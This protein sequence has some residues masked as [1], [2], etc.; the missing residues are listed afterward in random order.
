MKMTFALP[1]LTNLL[2]DYAIAVTAGVILLGLVNWFAF[3]RK[4]YT[5][6]SEVNFHY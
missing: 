6:P 3:A 2:A 1:P 5:G 4:H